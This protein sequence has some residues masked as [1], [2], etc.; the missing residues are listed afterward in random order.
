MLTFVL[1]FVVFNFPGKI[2]SC[3]VRVIL[4]WGIMPEKEC[5]RESEGVLAWGV[6]LVPLSN[7]SPYPV[8]LSCAMSLSIQCHQRNIIMT[9]AS[10]FS[11]IPVLRAFN[12]F[13]HHH[14]IWYSVRRSVVCSQW[15]YNSQN[16]Y[17]LCGGNAIKQRPG[18]A[19]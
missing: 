19:A 9:A 6:W 16:P 12:K 3:Y 10:L 8:L 15:Y 17:C 2:M 1:V 14:N 18:F 13:A 5:V 11:Y 7:F 4:S